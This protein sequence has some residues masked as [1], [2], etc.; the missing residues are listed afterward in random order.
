MYVIAVSDV[1]SFHGL[2]LTVE[3]ALITMGSLLWK[4]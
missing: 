4:T 3:I 1:M 2:L